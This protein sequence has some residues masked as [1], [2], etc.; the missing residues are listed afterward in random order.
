MT[1]CKELWSGFL[2]ETLKLMAQRI[3]ELHDLR[4]QVR[5]A[6][7]RALARQREM[8]IR[9]PR[10]QGTEVRHSRLNARARCLERV[11]RNCSL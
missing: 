9:R 4:R 6:E 8:A 11:N 10:R 5:D 3:A 7:A 2:R 1:G